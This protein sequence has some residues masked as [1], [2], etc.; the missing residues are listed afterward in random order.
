[1]NSLY[2]NKTI[3]YKVNK[4]NIKGLSKAVF[5]DRDGVINEDFHYIREPN[6][7]KLCK[8]ARELIREIYSKNIPIVIITNQSGI[9][10]KYLT[11]N[12]YKLV[13]ERIIQDLGRPNPIAAI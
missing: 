4:L 5:F 3:F 10:K 2:E 7:V 12:D 9:S 13:T 8:G 11:W 1:M 6:K